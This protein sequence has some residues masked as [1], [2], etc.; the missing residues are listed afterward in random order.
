MGNTPE[1]VKTWLDGFDDRT[2]KHIQFARH[3]QAHFG[4]GAP[5][6]LDLETIATLARYIDHITDQ[7]T[8]PSEYLPKL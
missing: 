7:D 8:A 5:G 4:H 2:R 1:P 3:Y 6:H